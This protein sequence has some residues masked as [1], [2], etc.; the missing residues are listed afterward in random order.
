MNKLLHDLEK[1]PTPNRTA[2]FKTVIAYVDEDCEFTAEG[3]AIAISAPDA[4]K[5]LAIPRPIPPFPPVIRAVFPSRLNKLDDIESPY[6]KCGLV[7][8][9]LA[10]MVHLACIH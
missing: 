6:R 5:A 7:I 4:A 3:V 8:I 2:Q 10:S 9:T 1:V